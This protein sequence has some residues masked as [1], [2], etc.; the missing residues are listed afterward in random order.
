MAD[1][2]NIIRRCSLLMEKLENSNYPS[3]QNL[4]DHLEANG[5]ERS[6]RTVERAIQQLR[7]QFQLEVAYEP[8]QNGY[9]IDW[10]SSVTPKSL[11]RFLEL[12]KT[13]ELLSTSAGSP[14]ETLLCVHFQEQGQLKGLQFLQPILE[15]I[16]KQRK[17]RFTHAPFHKKAPL[18]YV[19]EPYLL[20]E[21]ENRW[22]LVAT[23]PANGNKL[24]FYG[25]DRIWSLDVLPDTF[26]LDPEV[27]PV[28]AF[29]DRIGISTPHQGMQVVELSCNPDQA[30]Y[31][32]TLPL[33]HSQKIIKDDEDELRLQLM[34]EPNFEL[35]RKMLELTDCVTIRYPE[36]LANKV[37]GFLKKALERYANRE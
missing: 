29:N 31:L 4:I 12:G 34:V 8:S 25:V 14:S 1:I 21:F 6:S 15:A 36:W 17:I 23:I 18:T 22:Y 5:E 33:H 30:A 2:I 9:Y 10:E 26:H 28:K 11:Y 19:A 24:R 7:E 35:E 20:K 13:M 3:K 27:N 16:L 32:K 37:Q